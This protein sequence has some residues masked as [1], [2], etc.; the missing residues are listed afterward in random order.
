M[1]A[2]LEV[3]R[4]SAEVAIENDLDDPFM[5]LQPSPTDLIYQ[6]AE[7]PIRGV[8]QQS[9]QLP[10]QDGRPHN[11]CPTWLSYILND[12]PGQETSLVMVRVSVDT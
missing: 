3:A 1:L 7:S 6:S 9:S 5:P 8:A 2:G 4:A 10:A 12:N 11:K